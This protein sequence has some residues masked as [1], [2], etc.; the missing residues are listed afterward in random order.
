[1]KK[2]ITA[3]LLSGILAASAASAQETL[4]E[5][6]LEACDDDIAEFCDQVT[7]GEGRV[8]HCMAAHED[9]ISGEC[10]VALYDAASI[11]Q[12]ITDA[13]FYIAEAC[14]TEIETH[15]AETP[16]GEGRILTCLE[17]N[18]DSLGDACETALTDVLGE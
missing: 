6:V 14:E 5:H 10:A 2:H 11:L 3:I 12:A 16:A 4:L 13:I 1:M 8:V 7:P 18:A 9:K 17:G 15:C